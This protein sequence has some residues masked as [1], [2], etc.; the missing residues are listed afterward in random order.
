MSLN[1]YC[2]CKYCL[3]MKNCNCKY[4]LAKLEIHKVLIKYDLGCA[5][6][7]FKYYEDVQCN[8]NDSDTEYYSESD[9]NDLNIII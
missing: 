5:Q 7:I 9:E 3:K 8:N 6:I 4:C 2:H 1:I